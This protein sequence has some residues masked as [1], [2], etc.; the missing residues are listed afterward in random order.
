M[1]APKPL[2]GWEKA[3]VTESIDEFPQSCARFSVV[4]RK[5]L[6][7]VLE[8]SKKNGDI[9]V[10]E[11]VPGGNASRLQGDLAIG[12]GD[13]LISVTGITTTTAQVYG[14]TTV[15]GGETRVVVNT[16]GQSFDAIMAAIGSNKAGMDIKLEFQ[17]CITTGFA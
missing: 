10:A 9:Y 5:P 12:V 2:P 8:Q 6:G 13:I 7:L 1:A 17:R 11:V 4:L 15:R 3:S 14:E 16:R